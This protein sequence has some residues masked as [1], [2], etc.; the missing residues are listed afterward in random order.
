[1]VGLPVAL[2]VASLAELGYASLAGKPPGAG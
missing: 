2:L 1:V